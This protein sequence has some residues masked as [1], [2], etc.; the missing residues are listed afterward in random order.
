MIT[1][2]QI[3]A[4]RG[5]LEWRAEDLARE[6]GLARVSVSNLES[7]SVQPQEKTIASIIA[8]FDRNGIE[9]LEGEGVK[10]RQ[11]EVR[12]FRGRAGYRQF[13]DHVYFTLKDNG[14]RIRQFNLSDEAYLPYGDDYGYEHMKRMETIK[15]LDARVLTAENDCSFPAKYCKYRWLDKVGQR[16]VPYYVYN[17]FLGMLLFTSD[18]NIEGLCIKSKLLADK[19]SEQFEMFWAASTAPKKCGKK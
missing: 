19:Y 12:I 11:G 10:V 18:H 17:D 14:G 15:N 1:G 8:A 13:L 3:R 7:E 2:R 4:A 16:L 5:L 9:F 6:A